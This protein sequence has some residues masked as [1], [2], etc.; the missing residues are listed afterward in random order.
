MLKTV[1]TKPIKVRFSPRKLARDSMRLAEIMYQSGYRPDAIVA[2]WTG[3]TDIGVYVSKALGITE[4]PH[5]HYPIKAKSYDEDGHQLPWIEF[6]GV[7]ETVEMLQFHGA[8]EVC[9]VDDVLDSGRTQETAKYILTNGL[10]ISM[11]DLLQN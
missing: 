5:K 7:E 3:G 1:E 9:V 2:I 10:R 6:Y 8:R 11:D 4:V